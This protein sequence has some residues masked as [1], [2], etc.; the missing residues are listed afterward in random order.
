M[1]SQAVG[2]KGLN[3]V[4]RETLRSL[5]KYPKK[6]CWLIIMFTVKL[7]FEDIRVRVYP[8]CEFSKGNARAHSL[9]VTPMS[10][11]VKVLFILIS[12]TPGEAKKTELKLRRCPRRSHAARFLL[13]DASSKAGR[14]VGRAEG[15]KDLPTLRIDSEDADLLMILP[16]LMLAAVAD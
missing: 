12:I 15:L 8:I 6:T 14:A 16:M 3:T 4:R 7:Q 5:V 9:H 10:R 13:Q 11:N 2:G 1:V